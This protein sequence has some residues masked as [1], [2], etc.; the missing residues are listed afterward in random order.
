MIVGSRNHFS[1]K[2][3]YDQKTGIKVR[4]K[5]S[6]LGIEPTSGNSAS[7]V[8]RSSTCGRVR[9]DLIEPR[10]SAWP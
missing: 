1:S 3:N 9:G 10:N 8:P 6:S 4:Q 2:S 7:L 5:R